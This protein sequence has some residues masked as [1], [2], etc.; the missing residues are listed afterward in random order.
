MIAA[1]VAETGG[2]KRSSSN[3]NQQKR[4]MFTLIYT[5]LAKQQDHDDVD[6]SQQKP[7]WEAHKHQV[8]FKDICNIKYVCTYIYRL[9]DSVMYHQPCKFEPI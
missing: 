4:E 6:L 9:P 7:A 3:S 8:C 2:A 1:T 5:R